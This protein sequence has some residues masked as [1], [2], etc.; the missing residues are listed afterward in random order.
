VARLPGLA[1]QNLCCDYKDLDGD[2]VRINC[3]D[4]FAACLEELEGKKSIKIFI[5]E[6]LTQ[7]LQLSSPEVVVCESQDF[8]PAEDLSGLEEP[9][10]KKTSEPV[11]CTL[12]PKEERAKVMEAQDEE[13]SLEKTPK[14][15]LNAEKLEDKTEEEMMEYWKKFLPPWKHHGGRKGKYP[16]WKHKKAHKQAKF[17]RKFDEAIQKALPQIAVHV[18]QILRNGESSFPAKEMAPMANSEIH[19]D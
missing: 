1:K 2:H 18:A 4:D 19:K 12:I 8:V 16:W 5:K 3:Q 17:N 11:L 13:I 15:E 14:Q 9:V 7:T 6:D 10:P